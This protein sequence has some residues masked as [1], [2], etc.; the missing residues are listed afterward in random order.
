MSHISFF[1]GGRSVQNPKMIH[2][3]DLII[4][5]PKTRVI[6]TFAWLATKARITICQMGPLNQLCAPRHGGRGGKINGSGLNYSCTFR[7]VDFFRP[8]SCLVSRWFWL[9][10]TS[11]HYRTLFPWTTRFLPQKWY[12]LFQGCCS[13]YSSR[14]QHL[15]FISLS[16]MSI[17]G[18]FFHLSVVSSSN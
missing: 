8:R 5:P 1:E 14:D 15:L 12:L 6:A 13:L 10:I 18:W 3:V 4:L 9:R 16:V 11:G 7:F 17:F 2:R